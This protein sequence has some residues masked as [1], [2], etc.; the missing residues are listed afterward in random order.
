MLNQVEEVAVELHAVSY[1]YPDR[2]ASWA[3]R[4]VNAS[5]IAGKLTVMVGP[6]AAGKSTLMRLIMGELTPGEGSVRLCGR[7]V[8]EYRERERAALLAYVPQRGTTSVGF[9]VRQVV[10]M[11]RLSMGVSHDGVERAM[12]RAGVTELAARRYPHL[13]T[14]QQ[15]RVLL[16]RALAQAADGGRVMIADEPTSAMDLRHARAALQLL[17]SQAAAGAAVLVVLHDLNLALAF[18]DHVWLMAEGQLVADGAWNHVLTPAVLEPVYGVR[19]ETL[20]DGRGERPVF[21]VS[22][23]DL[24][25]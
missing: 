15:Q 18:A 17:K 14:G 20:D 3:V 6:N 7:V 4:G 2:R 1:A 8:G 23:R 10:E 5:L 25:C 19:I 13:S 12:Q 9:S 22:D 11:G 24:P 21:R 16:A